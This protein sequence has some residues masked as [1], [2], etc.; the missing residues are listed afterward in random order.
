MGIARQRKRKEIGYVLSGCWELN[1]DWEACVL[2]DGRYLYKDG[3]VKFNIVGGKFLFQ[4]HNKS[5]GS[6]YCQKRR[7]MGVLY[8]NNMY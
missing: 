4:K 5:K 8:K 6:L 2:E 3:G 1:G 7:V